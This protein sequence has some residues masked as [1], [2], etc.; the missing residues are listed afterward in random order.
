MAPGKIRRV[1]PITQP[2]A[3]ADQRAAATARGWAAAGVPVEIRADGS[4]V[5]PAATTR[6]NDADPRHALWLRLQ[7]D[8]PQAWLIRT[9]PSGDPVDVPL[10]GVD[11]PAL[12]AALVL[13]HAQRHPGD[14]HAMRAAVDR[15]FAA[16]G[17]RPAR[18]GTVTP[19]QVHAALAA[20]PGCVVGLTPCCDNHPEGDRP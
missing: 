16:A 10:S 5:L 7:S 20:V 3:S 19:Q 8:P 2:A 6:G 18:G 4:I 15:A 11:A 14:G 12:A 17:Y 1:A 9:G 13:F